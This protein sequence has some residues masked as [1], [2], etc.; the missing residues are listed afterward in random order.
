MANEKK[1][2]GR[3]E[4]AGRPT[5]EDKKI[6]FSTKLKK[7]TIDKLQYE[8]TRL[9]ISRGSVIDLLVERL[10]DIIEK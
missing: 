5:L 4:G 2:G 7:E 1:W 3:R 9:S 6:S 10:E 8:A